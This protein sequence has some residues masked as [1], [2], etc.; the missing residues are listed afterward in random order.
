MRIRPGPPGLARG[1]S[2][3]GAVTVALW[4]LVAGCGGGETATAEMFVGTWRFS[5][6]KAALLV[7]GIGGQ[8]LAGARIRITERPGGLVL[9]LGCR[10]RVP[11]EIAGGRARAVP[12][13]DTSCAMVVLDIDSSVS[14]ESWTL[15][16]EGPGGERLIAQ[17]RGT[18]TIR[19]GLPPLGFVLSAGTLVREADF[20]PHCG[21]ET[22]VGVVPYVREYP[23]DAAGSC[24][25]GVGMEGVFFFM[26]SANG[27]CSLG[28]GARGE[29]YWLQPDAARTLPDEP[30]PELNVS[31]TR[32][33]FCKV[34]GDLFRPPPPGPYGAP[35]SYALLRL[36]DRCPPGAI[37]VGKRV[38]NEATNNM[39]R[40][41]G[42]L[43]PNRSVVG[44][45]EVWT[46]L[47]FCLFQSRAGAP[48]SPSS[49]DVFPELGLP[50][51]VFH[52]FDGDQPAW[53]AS[54]RW[55]SSAGEPA[56]GAAENRY[57]PAGDGARILSKMIGERPH[58]SGPIATVFDLARVR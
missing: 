23:V 57:F 40:T 28:S 31:G 8:P 19:Q 38:P 30:C 25:T 41:A 39:N 6:D 21:G 53:V 44:E 24:P 13:A 16:T 36:G 42:A 35:T 33:W 55:L 26:D 29:P 22:A 9:D 27:S 46:E 2:V 17:A 4:A 56:G 10:C 48:E 37:E 47:H 1:V 12:A 49:A 3:A 20:E 51:A 54:K 7:A 58:T 5:D 34:D 32:L 18:T 11:L 15:E 50:Y 45:G 43:G 52:A 14:L